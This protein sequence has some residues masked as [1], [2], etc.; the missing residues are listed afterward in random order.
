MLCLMNGPNLTQSSIK[1]QNKKK[2]IQALWEHSPI[3]RTGLADL[4]GLNKAT[5]TNLINEIKDKN[6][7]TNVGQQKSKI[8]RSRNLIMFN[9]KYGLYA[10]IVIRPRVIHLALSDVFTKILWQDEYKYKPEDKP[11]FVLENISEMLS[12]QLSKYKDEFTNFLGIGIGTGSLLRQ[13]DDMMYAVHSI[14]WFNVPLGEYFRQQFKVPILVDTV[15]NNAMIGEKYFG[16]AKEVS[17]AVLINIGNGIGGGL[18]LDNK[19]YRGSDGFAGDIGHFMIDPN[20][21]S[22]PCGNRGCW[23]IMGSSLAIENGSLKKLIQRAENGEASAITLLDSIGHAIGIGV[24]NLIRVLN[25]E[26]VILG[27]DIV[28][29][30]KWVMNPC[31]TETKTRLWPFV[32]KRTNIRFAGLGSH[33]AIIGS[34]TRI[35][36]QMFIS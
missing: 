31:K 12:E 1:E 8:G 5:V 19:I 14:N 24:S 34:L 4:T 29:A 33:S 27:G 26:L 23:E 35:I 13:N 16:V 36:E 3:S 11:L 21:P 15:S 10:G 6:M 2:I 20:G 18:L 32:W 7:I 9:E 17:N 30:G 25:P 22:C 28:I